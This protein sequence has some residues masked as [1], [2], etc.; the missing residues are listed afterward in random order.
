M[1]RALI[2]L[3]ALAIIS[4]DVLAQSIERVDKGLQ[5][6]FSERKRGI[7]AGDFVVWNYDDVAEKWKKGGALKDCRGSSTAIHR[8]KSL[9]F[10]Q[11]TIDDER[12]L[13]VHVVEGTGTY[14][15]GSLLAIELDDTKD[16][17]LRHLD[18]LVENDDAT[19]SPGTELFKFDV[20]AHNNLL[21]KTDS[22]SLNTLWEEAEDGYDYYDTRGFFGLAVFPVRVKGEMFV[23][24]HVHCDFAPLRIGGSGLDH[25]KDCFDQGYF[26]M[27]Y[28]SFRAF[29]ESL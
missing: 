21:P 7:H 13:I 3:F 18:K 20:K 23:R 27:S 5:Y 15:K 28:Q 24:F 14:D 26:E 10:Y 29:V 16:D 11:G 4:G 8:L 17:I 25:D 9:D 6:E 1:S 22:A 19:F 12:V 2:L